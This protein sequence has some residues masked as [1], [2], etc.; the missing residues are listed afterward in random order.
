MFHKFI[1]EQLKN[2]DGII[3]KFILGSLWNRRNASLNDVTM[4]HLEV[5]KDDS[6]IDIGFGGGYLLEKIID[7]ISDGYISGID[8]SKAMVENF[9]KKYLKIIKTGRLDIQCAGVESIPYM[10]EH[11]TKATSVNSIF[12]WKEPEKG[13]SEVYRI[14]KK[15]GLFVLTYTCKKDLD[16][17]GFTRY[18]INTYTDEE[19]KTMMVSAGFEQLTIKQFSDLY[20]DF[21]LITGKKMKG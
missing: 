11:F 16:K 20:R 15:K 18:G 21:T 9:R 17:K 14:L 5:N 2:P 1:A 3:G 4:E 19:V 6:I 12:Y 10:N 7:R 8:S 13:I